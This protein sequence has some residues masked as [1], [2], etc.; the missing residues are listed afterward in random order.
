[1][2]LFNQA[3]KP[4]PIRL[5]IE[6]DDAEALNE[7]LL[8]QSVVSVDTEGYLYDKERHSKDNGLAISAQFSYRAENGIERILLWNHG[9]HGSNMDAVAPFLASRIPKLGHN[10]PHEFHTFANHGLLFSGPFWDMM[11]ADFSLD[12]SREGEHGLKS[13]AKDHLGRHRLSFPRTFGTLKARKDGRPYASEQLETPNLEEYLLVKEYGPPSSWAEIE[14]NGRDE[15]LAWRAENTAWQNGDQ[16]RAPTP[17]GYWG[18]WYNFCIY[19]TNDTWD[20]YSLYEFFKPKFDELP[21]GN[22]ATY[23]DYF[24][25]VAAAITEELICPIERRGMLLDLPFLAEM[26]AKCEEDMEQLAIQ[27]SEWAACPLEI[28]KATQLAMLLHGSGMQPVYKGASKYKPSGKNPKVDF[29][30]PGRE[31]PVFDKTKGG[32]PSTAADSLVKLQEWAEDHG[33]ADLAGLAYITAHAKADKQK[34]TYLEGM[35]NLAIPVPGTRFG[36]LHT[37]IGQTSATS[38]RWSSS[39]PNLQNVTSGKKDKYNLRDCFIA[40]KGKTLVVVDFAALEYRLLAHF[41]QD[42]TLIR[43]FHEGLDMHSLTAYGVFPQIKAAVDAEFGEFCVDAGPWVKEHY[44]DER[45]K[46]AKVI[47][48]EIIYGVG[49][50]KLAEQLRVSKSKGKEYIANWYKSYPAVRPWQEKTIAGARR[51]GHVRTL[52]GRY[53]FA[54]MSWLNSD[55]FWRKGAEE[56]SLVNAVIQGSAADMCCAAMLNLVYC[57]ELRELGM[58]IVMQV[59]DEVIM[60]VPIENVER[61]MEILRP[62]MERAFGRD[63]RVPFPVSVGWGPTWST[64]K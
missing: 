60:E 9:E 47:N 44:S 54:D 24:T 55:E 23:W 3:E 56:R 17:L 49:P 1:M 7:E 38:G 4:L 35:A 34:G 32:D 8:A 52:L 58:E 37:R 20:D 62:L 29:Y 11:V 18:R 43:V 27:A 51:S 22:S 64:A 40:P 5:V 6:R 59:H 10:L 33:R 16:P 25:K 48:F 53:R 50:G 15:F 46:Q 41:T 39:G 21:W 42:P 13:C 19:A 26:R 31:I 12:Q 57:E 30:I 63:L 28:G 36:R 45:D 14:A 61:V 2:R